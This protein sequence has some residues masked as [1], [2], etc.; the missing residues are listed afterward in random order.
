MK[1]SDEIINTLKDVLH[2]SPEAAAAYLFGSA[3]GDEPVVNDLD[4][5][6]LLS[7]RMD[8]DKAYFDLYA[9]F[10]QVM[11]LSGLRPD[12]LF[13]DLQEAD[14]HVLCDAVNKGILLKDESPELLTDRIESLSRYFLENEFLIREA[15]RL[16][17]EEFCD[18]Q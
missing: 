5:L 8:K 4:I 9:R 16:R 12:I 2:N 15:R 14:P 11:E 17:K 18:G 7:P 6:V 1:P 10:M 3:A 13:F